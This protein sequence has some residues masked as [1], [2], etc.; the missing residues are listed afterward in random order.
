MAAKAQTTT[1]QTEVPNRLLTELQGLVT[2]GWS[3]TLDELVLD[4]L[5]RYADSHGQELMEGFV[6]EDVEWG[7]EG[8]D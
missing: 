3:R 2:A 7:L 1:L 5:R 4:A 8:V 6:R